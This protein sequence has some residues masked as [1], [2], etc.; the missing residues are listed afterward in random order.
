MS[1]GADSGEDRGP[2]D[3]VLSGQEGT[4]WGTPK[5]GEGGHRTAVN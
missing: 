1:A 5:R 2:A 4:P 3:R